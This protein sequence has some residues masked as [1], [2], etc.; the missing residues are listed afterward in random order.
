M[1]KNPDSKVR[2]KAIES[3][4][5]RKGSGAAPDVLKGIHDADDQVRS[6]ALYA[7]VGSGMELPQEDLSNLVLKDSSADVRFL[8]LQALSNSNS[9]DLR[10]IAE[11]AANDPNETVRDAALE[12]MS[13]LDAPT[14]GGSEPST[15][16][17]QQNQPRP[18]R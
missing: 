4:V 7:A 5:E 15:A 14:Q 8:A 10:S 13:R 2:G 9:P 17:Q 18:S 12:V 6:R 11:S 3:L 16:S 1:L